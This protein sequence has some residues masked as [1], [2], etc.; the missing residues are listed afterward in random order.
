M[1]KVGQKVDVN[2]SIGGR[3]ITEKDGIVG[4]IFYSDVT[5]GDIVSVLVGGRK[6]W[7]YQ[8]GRYWDSNTGSGYIEVQR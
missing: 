4:E 2:L 3:K 5:G 1:F 8:N 7:F 6:Y